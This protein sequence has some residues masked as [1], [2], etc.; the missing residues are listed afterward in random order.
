MG[1]SSSAETAS[2]DPIVAADA[3]TSPFLPATSEDAPEDLVQTYDDPLICCCCDGG[4]DTD[5]SLV[6]SPTHRLPI[7]CRECFNC[8][9][10]FECLQKCSNEANKSVA[11][12]EATTEVT[13]PDCMKV[14]FDVNDVHPDRNLCYLL[15]TV[16]KLVEE[17][18][19]MAA[20]GVEESPAKL[21]Y[22]VGQKLKKVRCL[23]IASCV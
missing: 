15:L 23:K 6:G 1:A 13:C 22:R 14:G 2:D 3:T 17:R 21:K 19:A 11:E 18:K 10:C 16:R 20:L 4:F 8:T 12:E 7:T 5:L 9:C